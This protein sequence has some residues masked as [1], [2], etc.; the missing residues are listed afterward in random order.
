MLY[1]PESGLT[2]N[3]T[4][5]TCADYRNFLQSSKFGAK[6]EPKNNEQL[7]E[8]QTIPK[9][10]EPITLCGLKVDFGGNCTDSNGQQWIS[11]VICKQNGKWGLRNT[12]Q[13]K[14]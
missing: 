4:I 1:R 6:A 12:L 3:T 5:H 2:G 13:K 7:K 10:L 9:F 11:D 14:Q 8:K